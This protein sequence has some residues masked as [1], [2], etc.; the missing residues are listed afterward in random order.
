VV[1]TSC[2]VPLVKRENQYG[3]TRFQGQGRHHLCSVIPSKAM[4]SIKNFKPEKTV[5]KDI[6]QKMKIALK[7]LK[8]IG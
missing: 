2:F 7:N 4:K 5:W 1:L 3:L 6:A 8:C